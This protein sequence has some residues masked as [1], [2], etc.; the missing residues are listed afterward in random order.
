MLLWMLPLAFAQ[1]PEPT[2]TPP[3][4]ATRAVAAQ[5]T[6]PKGSPQ[7]PGAVAALEAWAFPEM[8]EEQEAAR[9]GVRT[10]GLLVIQGGE[11]IYERYDRGF[12]QDTPHLTWSVSKTFT[13]ALTAIAVREGRLSLDDSI[14][15]YISPENLDNCKITVEDLLT[16]G[17]GI[18]W[19][20][21]YES[22][23]TTSS[24]VEML[25]GKTGPQDMAGF[26]AAQPRHTDPGEVYQY[27]SGDTTLLAR[28][29]QNAMAPAHGAAFPYTMLFE[30][31]SMNSIVW[32]RDAAGTL[33]GSSY[34]YGSPRDLARFGQLWLDDGCWNG[35][36]I[37]PEGWVQMS[38]TVNEP[39]R[40]STRDWEP[41]DVQ[42]MQMWLNQPLQEQS[43]DT[44]PWGEMAPPNAYAARGHW[45]QAITMVPSYDMVIVR[46]GD[47]RGSDWTFAE[48]MD[49][50]LALEAP[51]KDAPSPRAGVTRQVATNTVV[52]PQDFKSG[53]LNIGSGYAA[54]LACS[55]AYV[56][57]QSR[58]YC[59]EWVRASPDITRVRYDDEEKT[60]TA[61]IMGLLNKRTARYIN[62]RDGCRLE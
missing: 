6:W 57:E 15:E 42:G 29:I 52:P 8:T 16:F 59:E 26:V 24:V 17:S 23:P 7:N 12:D 54:K 36:R 61:R 44:A 10:E 13:N 48:L 18:L 55:C 4:C 38:T 9:T 5:G 11:I 28:I 47:D 56:M 37:F 19:K 32:E 1:D 49:R 30:P 20:E 34:L 40:Q 60:A 62:E 3:G 2:T 39:I 51:I 50:V 41:G 22:A 46:V 25:Y 58:P 45:R 43:V 33:V 14:C 27:S 21:S 35:E 31:L 53:L